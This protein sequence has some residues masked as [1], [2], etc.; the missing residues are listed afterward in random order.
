MGPAEFS[1]IAR[2]VD[3]SRRRSISCRVEQEV[4]D[5]PR[6]WICWDPNAEP[7]EFPSA[8]PNRIHWFA[9]DS[10]LSTAEVRETLAIVR[11]RASRRM[12]IMMCPRAWT[13]EVDRELKADGATPWPD[14]VYPVLTRPAAPAQ[15][16]RPCPFTTRIVTAQEAPP[17]LAQGASW[18]SICGIGRAQCLL[19]R[20]I[21]ELHAAFDGEKP[22]AF[23]F[24][25]MDG[26]FGYLGSAGT[27][28][29]R[30]GQGAQ[31]ALIAARITRAAELGARWCLSETNTAVPISLRNL[32]RCGFEEVFYWKVYRW[33]DPRAA[34]AAN[35]IS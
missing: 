24:L 32:K 2:A 21:G 20:G 15:P 23:T 25:M 14:V 9:V 22:V 18:Y 34:P 5:V 11:A 8:S 16:D 17:I 31:S 35:T 19:D 26:E 13:T 12:Y 33:D 30:R 4:A 1:A 27:D 29:A 10:P 28:P 6:G 7:G 3:R